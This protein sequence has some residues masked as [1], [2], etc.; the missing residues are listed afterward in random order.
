MAG[1]IKGTAARIIVQYPLALFLHC[2]SHC[3][4]LV[5]VK[6]LQI[7]NIRNMICVVGKVYIFFDAQP[8][9]QMALEKTITGSQPESNIHELKDLCHTRCIQRIDAMKIFQLLHN[10]IVDCLESIY[11]DGSSL[12]SSDSLTDARS[13]QLAICTTDFISSLVI[14]NFCPKYIQAL[15][16]NLQA[17]AALP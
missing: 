7:S 4:N 2:S 1:S 9:R 5:V 17:E 15:T 3:L 11:S 12:W 16:T 6:S 14:T 13:I 8:K 10:S